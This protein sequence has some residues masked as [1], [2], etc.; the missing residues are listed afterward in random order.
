[1][2]HDPRPSGDHITV[3]GI[4]ARGHHG[5]YEH[6]K[7]DGQ[8]FI[9]DVTVYTDLD[10]ASAS[11]SLDHT[12]HYGVLAELV[13]AHIEA[14]PVDLIETLAERIAAS[15]LDRWNVPTVTVTVHKPHAPIPVPFSDVTVTITRQR[16]E[17]DRA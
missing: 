3:T 9:V 5:V 8:D 17:A 1:M 4:R 11:D 16:S 14:D 10:T 7:R 13:V 2:T 6:E 12:V 15:V